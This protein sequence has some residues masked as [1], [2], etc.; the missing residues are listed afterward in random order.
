MTSICKSVLA[1]LLVAVVA[2]SAADPFWIGYVNY[3]CNLNNGQE[4]NVM[5]GTVAQCES[6]CNSNAQCTGFDYYPSSGS[7]FFSK[8]QCMNSLETAWTYSASCTY[9]GRTIPSTSTASTIALTCSE[10][11]AAYYGSAA[12]SFSCPSNCATS[13]GDVQGSGPYTMASSICRAAIHAGVITDAAGGSFTLTWT[14]SSPQFTAS[15]ANGVTSLQSGFWPASFSFTPY[16]PQYSCHDIHFWIPEGVKLPGDLQNPQVLN[17][18]FNN[19]IYS[20]LPPLQAPAM[21]NCDSSVT[22]S[23]ATPSTPFHHTQTDPGYTPIYGPFSM[24]AD[25]T[26]TYI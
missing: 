12:S 17:T 9:Y 6:W 22:F 21:I 20:G 26:F 2:T 7:C 24:N 13:T 3:D 19:R 23:A 1:F 16:N 11:S 4:L 15:T 5:T 25:G 14:G 8:E 18:N 10:N